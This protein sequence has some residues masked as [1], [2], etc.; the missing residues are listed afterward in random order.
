MIQFEQRGTKAKLLNLNFGV[1]RI[2]MTMTLLKKS[3]RISH[4]SVVYSRTACVLILVE[5]RCVSVSRGRLPSNGAENERKPKFYSVFVTLNKT[6]VLWERTAHGR[7]WN[8]CL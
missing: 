2:N 6:C 5:E 4:L 3:T 1:Y 7:S 8:I